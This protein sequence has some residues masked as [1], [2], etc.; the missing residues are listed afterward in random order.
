MI[1][2]I[3]ECLHSKEIRIKLNESLENKL[4]MIKMMSILFILC[5]L[6]QSIYS[7]HLWNTKLCLSTRC[8]K[9]PLSMVEKKY[10]DDLRNVA[11]IGKQKT[12]NSSYSNR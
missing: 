8:L 6:I 7:F 12:S 1:G 2:E 11:I 9:H 4:Q 5:L 10:R 3:K